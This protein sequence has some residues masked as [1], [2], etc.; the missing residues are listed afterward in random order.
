MNKQIYDPSGKSS[1]P[2]C[3]SG[4]YIFFTGGPFSPGLCHSIHPPYKTGTVRKKRKKK[5]KYVISHF[6][7]KIG[8]P[9]FGAWLLPAFAREAN[10]QIIHS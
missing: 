1:R 6:R 8:S 7:R 2:V 3:R 4:T 10:A 5:K 9:T